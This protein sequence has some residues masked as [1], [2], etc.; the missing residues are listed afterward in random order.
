M[1]HIGFPFRLDSRGRT[2]VS[3]DD[4]HVRGLIEQVLFTTPGER[5]NRPGFGS[6]LR[7]LVFEPAAGELATATRSLVQA[8]L[9]QWLAGEVEVHAVEVEVH[10]ATV[11]V[12]VRYRTAAMPQPRTATFTGRA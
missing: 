8:A 7:G 4:E 11:L 9:Q 3:S 10:D 5:L 6:G 12:S 1:T 2:A